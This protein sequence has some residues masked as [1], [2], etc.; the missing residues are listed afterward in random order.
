MAAASS[1]LPL[2]D[3][4]LKNGAR[5]SLLHVSLGSRTWTAVLSSLLFCSSLCIFPLPWHQTTI[6]I[7]SLPFVTPLPIL[8]QPTLQQLLTVTIT[9]LNLEQRCSCCQARPFRQHSTRR[10]CTLCLPPSLPR[11][12]PRPHITSGSPPR[13]HIT[14]T[15][16]TTSTVTSTSST[17][18][19]LATPC[20]QTQS[21]PSSP[22]PIRS[23]RAPRLIPWSCHCITMH[24]KTM[25]LQ[26]PLLRTRADLDMTTKGARR[27]VMRRMPDPLP[28]RYRHL[29]HH[30]GLRLFQTRK[31]PQENNTTPDQ[32]DLNLRRHGSF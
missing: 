12:N 3:C 14:S 10:T 17:N 7:S 19:T 30:H 6:S 20:S 27:P 11:L 32:W 25:V 18:T 23:A 15:T 28:K 4:L 31:S 16:T 8:P 2:C 1:A 29:H 26:S 9:G 5:S 24:A 13:I 22:Q 21:P